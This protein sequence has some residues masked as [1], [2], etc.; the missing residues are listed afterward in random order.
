MASWLP[1]AAARC[2]FPKAEPSIK[3]AACKISG[4]QANRGSLPGEVLFTS[5]VSFIAFISFMPV[6]DT[7]GA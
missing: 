6:D 7:T 1:V 2:G 4:N 3:R 5:I